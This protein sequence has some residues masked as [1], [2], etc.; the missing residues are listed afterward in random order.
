MAFGLHYNKNS[1]ENKGMK[2]T[3]W[4]KSSFQDRGQTVQ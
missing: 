3:E 4:A 1:F 2:S